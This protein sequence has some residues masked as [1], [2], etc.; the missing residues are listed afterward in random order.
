MCEWAGWGVVSVYTIL[1]RDLDF[2]CVFVCLF[3]FMHVCESACL[4]ESV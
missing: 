3:V 4:C 2:V 1:W